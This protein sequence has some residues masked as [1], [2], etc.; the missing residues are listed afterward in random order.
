[1]KY[2]YPAIFKSDGDDGS[3]E[4]SFPDLEVATF[5]DSFSNAYEMA[6]DVLCLALATWE[7]EGI[8][9]SAPSSIF[10]LPEKT[11]SF[12]MIECDTDCYHQQ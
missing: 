11:D 2:L 4:V 1:M 8:D 10:D 9:F 6:V 12:A 3:V 5:G 7:E